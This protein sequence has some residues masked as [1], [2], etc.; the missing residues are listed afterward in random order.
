M[1]QQ[2]QE[3]IKC[4]GSELS[5][6][7]SC[8]GQP[9]QCGE[10]VLEHW[11]LSGPSVQSPEARGS[12][13]RPRWASARTRRWEHGGIPPEAR[14][15]GHRPPGLHPLPSSAPK[16]AARGGKQHRPSLRGG[17]E[18][19]QTARGRREQAAS[20]RCPLAPGRGAA[21]EQNRREGTGMER[22]RE[23]STSG[24]GHTTS[25]RALSRMGPP[26]TCSCQPK[27][28]GCSAGYGPSHHLP[29]H[30]PPTTPTGGLS[31]VPGGGDPCAGQEA[32]R[33]G[34]PRVGPELQTDVLLQGLCYLLTGAS[35]RRL[36]NPETR[37]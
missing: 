15:E 26:R 32:P 28:Y 13:A 31:R 24:G 12:P 10:S 29:P 23:P 19:R 16:V 9:E 7:C 30:S 33:L 3:S 37:P 25:H 27:P 22:P 18:P 2:L 35:A 5:E 8:L 17:P 36:G 21:G 34:D 11:T 1:L 20:H 4:P 14:C 6:L